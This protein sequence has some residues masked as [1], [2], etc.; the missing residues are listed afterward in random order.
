MYVWH[1]FVDPMGRATGLTTHIDEHY[2]H[3]LRCY[4]RMLRTLLYIW[5]IMSAIWHLY[6]FACA[7]YERFGMFPKKQ[8]NI[9]GE[10]YPV[11]MF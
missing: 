10:A 9:R 4:Y 5:N 7:A 3:F 6:P 1:T 8:R 11:K 2:E